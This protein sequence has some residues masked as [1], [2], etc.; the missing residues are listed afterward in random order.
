MRKFA[1]VLLLVAPT[2]FAAERIVSLGSCVTE[3]LYAVGVGEQ[4]VGVDT[5]S[6]WPAAAQ[7]LPQVGYHRTLGAEGILSL[8]PT[9]VIGTTQAGP[10]EALEKVRRAGV[11]VTLLDEPKNLV[12]ALALMEKIAL[13]AGRPEQ[14][15]ELIARINAQLKQ[16]KI[17]TG[18]PAK[19]LV[20]L[21][22]HGGS[23]LAAG[24]DTAADTMIQ[25]AGGLNAGGEFT[26]FKPLSVESLMRIAPEFIVVPD[27]ALPMMGGREAVLKLPGIAETPAGKNGRLVVMDSLLLLGLGPRL[28]EGVAQLS[29]AIH[30]KEMASAE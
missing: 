29:A 30:A 26:G 4:V 20:L 6:R 8:N 24:S 21:S 10:P 27:H 5:S 16:L 3:T 1:L 22:A 12:S 9:R 13:E 11:S 28:G 7:K 19:V 17:P 18:T 25:L 14:G 2:V 23:P 15:R